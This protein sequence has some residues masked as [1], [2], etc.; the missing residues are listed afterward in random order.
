MKMKPPSDDLSKFLLA[1]V[2]FVELDGA[3]NLNEISRKQS[4]P[5]QTLRTR[6]NLLADDGFSV[7]VAPDFDKLGLERVKVFLELSP[8][9]AKN[10]MAFFSILDYCAGLRS[11]A[12]S[13]YLGSFDCEF[14]IPTGTLVELKK[15]LQRLEQLEILRILELDKILWREVLML[16]AQFYDYSKKQWDVDF[17]RLSERSNSE[18]SLL[19][20]EKESTRFDHYDLYMLKELEKQPW[21]KTVELA[22]Q[23]NVDP[24]HA[25]Y[26][27][28]EHV[29]GKKLIKNF[30]L[31][32]EGSKEARYLKHSIIHQSYFFKKIS[33]EDAQSAMSVFTSLPFTWSQLMTEDG[34]YSAEVTFPLANY[35]EATQYLSKEL[36]ARNLK[37]SLILQKDW[38]CLATFTI[39]YKLFDRENSRWAFNAERAL[40]YTLP[41]IKS[42]V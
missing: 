24:S 6:M 16:Q 19:P 31:R 7:A 20:T 38:S 9:T 32:W 1:I 17:S 35:A 29:F 18:K 11:C 15:F 26:H 39:P 21:I 12:K 37:P 3:R 22:R 14:T 13:M 2:P 34:T 8:F 10:P 23:L 36:L 25:A 42:Q 27:L 40:E 30:R 41:M 4:I 33:W 5:Y 28:N